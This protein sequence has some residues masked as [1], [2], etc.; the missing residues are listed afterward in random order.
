MLRMALVSLMVVLALPAA[1]PAAEAGQAAPLQ[2]PWASGLPFVGLLLAIAILPLVAEHWWHKNR[3]KLLVS[4][5]FGAPVASYLWVLGHDGQHALGHILAEYLSFIVL[6]GALYT[7]SGG[8]LIEG[9]LRGRPFSNTV[10]LAIGAV[11][12]S[13]IG[14]TGAS[15]LLIRP[16]LRVNQGR[17]RVAHLPVFFIFIVS[18][19]GG[20]LTPLGDPPLFLGFLRKVPFE[21]TLVNLWREWLVANG[22]VLTLFWLVDSFANRGE[23]EAIRTEAPRPFRIRGIFNFVLLAGVVG[24]VLARSLLEREDLRHFQTYFVAEAAQVVLALLSLLITPRGLRKENRFT[25]GPIIEVAVLFVGIFVAM[26]PALQLLKLHG[27]E[28]PVREPWQFFWT[29]GALSS[30]LD[31]A[32]TYVTFLALGQGLGLAREVVDVPHSILAA[33]SVGAVSMGANSYI[34]N[35]PN[36]MVKAIAE[37]QGVKM[38]TFFGYM[39]YSGAILLPLFVIVT[40]VFFRPGS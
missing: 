1:A 15:M 23:P 38:P 27:D 4:L 13:F 37:E 34:G 21:W 40:L 14:T 6:L 3:N 29:T 22:S 24:A 33:I 30:F 25:W 31:N 17:R 20:L 7:I 10:L 8:I 16:F 19:F 12:A 32:P 39:G 26:V 5:L 9:D 35:A 36:F 11:L 18:N 2:V 28:L